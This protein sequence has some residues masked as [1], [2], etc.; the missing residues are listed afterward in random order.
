V[1]LYVLNCIS[2]LHVLFYSVIVGTRCE[3]GLVHSPNMSHSRRPRAIPAVKYPCGECNRE[4]V[5]NTILCGKCDR[6]FHAKCESLTPGE[7][8]SLSKICDVDYV[9][10]N[11]RSNEAG[12]DFLAGLRRMFGFLNDKDNLKAAAEAEAIYLKRQPPA[13]SPL[14]TN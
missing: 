7:L 8:K 6:W 5:S 9:C 1:Y 12:F 13:V 14:F 2:V 3:L 10:N 11:C 4:C